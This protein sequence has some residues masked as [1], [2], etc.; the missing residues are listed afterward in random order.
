MTSAARAGV[1]EIGAISAATMRQMDLLRIPRL[2][3]M[4]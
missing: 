4:L 2:P 1:N 3:Q